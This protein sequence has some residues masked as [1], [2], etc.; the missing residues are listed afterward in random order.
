MKEK[1]FDENVEKIYST[2]SD[3]QK[4]EYIAKENT[5]DKLCIVLGVLPLILAVMLLV[6][7][8]IL[9]INENTYAL[10]IAGIVL[11]VF[12][13][14]IA[15]WVIRSS[16]KELKETDEV[17]IK[18]RIRSLELQKQWKQEEA[19]K[20]LQK[21]SQYRLQVDKIKNVF[22]V[23]SYTEVSDKLH[24]VLNYQ[25]IIQTRMYK[26][27][28]EYIDGASRIVTAAENSK[29]YGVLM[30]LVSQTAEQSEKQTAPSNIEQLREYKKLLDDGIITQEEFEAKKKELL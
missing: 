2:L 1:K 10:L 28:V 30:P 24:A 18:T 22:I 17:K 21:D 27:K 4:A 7:G 8:T 25:E 20:Q 3:E 15:Q 16:L 13:I 12:T 5:K 26:F 14:L 9:L 6:A 19:E 11:T 29:E 23:D